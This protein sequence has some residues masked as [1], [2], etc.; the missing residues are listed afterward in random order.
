MPLPL[1]FLTLE[2]ALQQDSFTAPIIANLQKDPDSLPNYHLSDRKLFFQERLV[3]P[4]SSPIRA[5]LIEESHLT[6]PGGHGGFLKTFKRLSG[7]FYWPQMKSD[8][9][10]F[11]QQC[12]VCQQNKYETLS[13]AGLLQPIPTPERI[14]EDISLDFIVGLPKSATYDTI[15]VVV[16]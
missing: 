8:I 15:L 4:R 9:K 1:D 11:I 6:P 16:D 5:K 12:Y 7:T 2:E 13:P 3:I 14:W 10:N